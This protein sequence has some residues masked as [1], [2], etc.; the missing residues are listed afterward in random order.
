MAKTITNV[1]KHV[2]CLGVTYNVFMADNTLLSPRHNIAYGQQHHKFLIMF[3][4][5]MANGQG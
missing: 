4:G 1:V 2:W 5:L 3:M